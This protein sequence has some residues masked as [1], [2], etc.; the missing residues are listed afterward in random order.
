MG[1]A[2]LL[3]SLSANRIYR[4]ASRFSLARFLFGT[5]SIAL[6]EAIVSG[7]NKRGSE[8][9]INSHT[10]VTVRSRPVNDRGR[11]GIIDSDKPGMWFN[12]GW[13]DLSPRIN[14]QR[15]RKWP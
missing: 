14:R 8:K 13:I 4:L 7:K 11:V 5:P 9:F 1:R 2:C 15:V 6:T 10:L 12:F 3:V